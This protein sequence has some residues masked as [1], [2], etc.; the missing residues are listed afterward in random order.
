[1]AVDMPAA[2]APGISDAFIAASSVSVAV[3]TSQ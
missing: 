1:V 3:L 2:T